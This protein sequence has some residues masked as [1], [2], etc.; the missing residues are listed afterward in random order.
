MKK[1]RLLR[2]FL[3]LAAC[4]ASG[5]CGGE[6]RPEIRTETDGLVQETGSGPE[7]GTELG[8]TAG[9]GGGET[10]PDFS[11]V[12]VLQLRINEEIWKTADLT[13]YLGKDYVW[14]SF[15]VEISELTEG[16]NQ[17]AL[18][19][20][21]YNYG[22]LSE[23]SVDL[24]FTYTDAGIDSYFSQD[25]M[26]TWEL[27][28]D[29]YADII[30]EL[31]D[32]KE[33][34]EFPETADYRLDD[35]TV[36]GI[37][38]DNNGIYNACRT[39]FLEDLSAYRSARLSALVHVGTDLLKEPEPEPIDEGDGESE[40]DAEA[41]VLKVKLNGGPCER[42]DLREYLGEDAVWVTVPLD[43]SRLR[44]GTNRILLDSN[45][46]N[47]E[48]FSDTSVDI[49]FSPGK[50]TQDTEL[51]TDGRLS[52]IKY[53]DHRYA[54]L[55]LELHNRETGEWE[56][57]P[58]EESYRSDK[59]HMVIGKFGGS[60]QPE[61]YHVRRAFVL[62]ET[63]AYDEV[64]ACIQIHVGERLEESWYGLEDSDR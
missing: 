24:F 56:R 64:R 58:G 45:V 10:D 14:V 27:Y 54:N 44:E 40:L 34:K 36:L 49:Y 12:P 3:L 38:V 6:D 35:N 41:P 16:Y 42:V 13:P 62:E 63:A 37:F 2:M 30:L 22:N 43:V 20:N 51:S 5:G 26:S 50:G 21:A 61:Q 53:E 31:Y 18:H 25:M 60:E 9:F 55:C 39:I 28:S 48:N 52:W 11:T 23:N 32:G 29:R 8:E 57:V 46:D 17:F 7:Q 19:S 15:P 33:W 59:E 1:K 47:Q 4:L